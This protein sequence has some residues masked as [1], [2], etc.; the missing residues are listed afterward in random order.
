MQEMMHNLK[1]LIICLILLT[2]WSCEK[3]PVIQQGIDELYTPYLK[4]ERKNEK[5]TLIWGKPACNYCGGCVCPQL[6]PDHFDILMSTSNHSELNYY[7]TVSSN[8]FE[9][10]IDNLVNGTPYY[11]AIKAVGQNGQYTISKTIMVIPNNPENIQ[12]LFQ[13][14]DEN[15]EHGTWSPDESSI[16]FMGDYTWNNGNNSSQSVFTSIPSTN[17]KWLIEKSSSSPEWSP[18]GQKIAYHTHNGE[19]QPWQGYTPTHISIYNIQDSTTKRLTAGNS[20]NFRPTWSP[21]GNWIAF[22]SDKAGGSEYNIWR[23][24]ADSGTAIQ[25]TSD[26]NDLT[27]LT[28]MTEYSPQKL[29]WSKDGN[30]IAF[31]RLTKIN[32]EYIFDIYSVPITGGSRTTIVTSQW[33]DYCPA[34]SPNGSSIAFV[35]NRSG[36]NEIWTMDLQTKKLKQI[37]GSSEQWIFGGWGKIEWSSSGDKIMFTSNSDNFRTL[38]IVVIN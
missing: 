36:L 28:N 15:S 38:F 22:L 8:I 31:S 30:D 29:S 17:E 10:S 1:I 23:I 2:I 3:D 7:S 24:P 4:S 33:D 12:P 26:F 35:S 16:A 13:T 25:V 6:D 34:Y 5:V 27:D 20:F 9:V 19:T 32:N 21:D 37:T 11:F 14:I 18:I